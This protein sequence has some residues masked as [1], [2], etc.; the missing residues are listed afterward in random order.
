MNNSFETFMLMP[1]E[2][3]KLEKYIQAK[4]LQNVYHAG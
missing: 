1:E 3:F 4:T 2:L